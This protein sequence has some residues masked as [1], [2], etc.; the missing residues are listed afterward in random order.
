MKVRIVPPFWNDRTFSDI[1][2]IIL[3]AYGTYTID[4]K[5]FYLIPIL[6]C[7]TVLVLMIW[8]DLRRIK[9][10]AGKYRRCL[11]DRLDKS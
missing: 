4:D 10:R 3:A 7:Y 1:G 9:R 2:V 11:F 5:N 6:F 8:Y